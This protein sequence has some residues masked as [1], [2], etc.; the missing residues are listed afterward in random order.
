MN[1]TAFSFLMALAQIVILTSCTH[2]TSQNADTDSGMDASFD[3]VDGISEDAG[4]GQADA[5][6]TDDGF[7]AGDGDIT[8]DDDLD[9]DDDGG[10]SDGGIDG[11]DP[12][13]DDSIHTDECPAGEQSC[14]DAFT[15]HF[16]A[17]TPWGRQWQD[18][19]CPGAEGCFHGECVAKACSDECNLGDIDG[20]K[21]CELFDMD[22]GS[23]VSS[24]PV[25]WMHDRARAYEMW[26]RRDGLYFGG[27]SN[28]IY[29][30]PPA[31]SNVVFHGGMGDSSIWTGTYLAA[32]SLR[33]LATG[34][35][36][37]RRQVIK[38]VNTLHLWFNVSGDPGVLARWVAPAGQSSDTE[39][40]CADPYHHCG[41][42]YNG[43]IYDY[44]GDISRDQY[45]GVMLGYALAYQALGAQ[46]EQTRALIREDVVELV[47]E[48]MKER[49]MPVQITINGVDWPIQYVNVRFVVLCTSEMT[50]DGAVH[51]DLDTGNITD[52]KMS[53][54]QEFMPNWG[55]MISQLPGFGSIT[56]IPRAG[57]AIMLAS[58]FRVAME[59]T[60]DVPGY[61]DDYLAFR[62]YYYNNPPE[63]G[64]NIDYWMEIVANTWS[65]TD[66][67]GDK[68]YGNN[69]AME[70]MYNLSRL[71]DNETIRK[72]I[73]EDII[74]ARMWPEHEFTKNC[75]FFYIYAAADPEAYADAAAI[76]SEQLAGFPP[77]PRV[78]VAVDLRSDPR[79][80]PHQSGCDNQTTRDKAVDVSERVVSDF[81]WQRNPW[82][83]YDEGVVQLTFPGVDY[84]V[85]YWMGRYY[86]HL[87]DDTPGRCLTWH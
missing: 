37:A 81:L 52:S 78:R 69:I 3:G 20:G 36:D 27:V 62:E 21:R 70:P 35:A 66:N 41:V 73:L 51:F 76:A 46:D 83:L 11:S 58:F 14:S 61:E 75:F 10:I 18:E 12:G 23:W 77:P 67:C 16:C 71:E 29:S 57:S 85:A 6:T 87:H 55:D 22:S 45:Q 25:T 30:D 43:Q 7:D 2:S 19:V 60:K 24:D 47:H 4:D 56:N 42:E 54:F 64:N 40:D 38:L 13:N 63:R 79:Y 50:A 49:T 44:L 59:V 80:Q 17:D 9:M 15:R 86:G 31:Y 28:A 33:L 68:Y 84:L 5:H 32:E 8:G 48:L 53:G 34:S 74:A 72:R 1:R 26:L 39:L 82:K 65:Y